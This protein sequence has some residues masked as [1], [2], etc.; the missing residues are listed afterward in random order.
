MKT[1]RST[2]LSARGVRIYKGPAEN[3]SGLGRSIVTMMRAAESLLRKVPFDSRIVISGLKSN[4]RGSFTDS[5]PKAG[6]NWR[7]TFLKDSEEKANMISC[8]HIGPMSSAK[9]PSTPET[10]LIRTEESHFRMADRLSSI[11][12]RL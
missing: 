4:G 11:Y 2:N 7:D 3:R 12:R 10:L 1:L 8:P 5:Q 6:G 9:I